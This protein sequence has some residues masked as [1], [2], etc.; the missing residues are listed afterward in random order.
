M[1]PWNMAT[2]FVSIPLDKVKVV[3]FKFF[4]IFIRYLQPHSLVTFMSALILI[5][6]AL[7]LF[8]KVAAFEVLDRIKLIVCSNEEFLSLHPQPS[9]CCFQGGALS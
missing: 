5:E 2:I 6:I 4:R 3:L 9:F 7:Q 8:G 1:L